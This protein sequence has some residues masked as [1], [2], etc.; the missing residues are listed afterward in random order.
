MGTFT[1]FMAMANAAAAA[2][3]PTTTMS[4]NGVI[5]VPVTASTAAI[6]RSTHHDAASRKLGREDQIRRRSRLLYVVA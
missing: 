5:A 2:N 1:K 4:G 6:R 3:V